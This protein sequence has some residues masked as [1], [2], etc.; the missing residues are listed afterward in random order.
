MGFESLPNRREVVRQAVKIGGVRVYLDTGF[1]PDGRV[2]E[3]FLAVEQTG[4]ERRWLY[5]EAA[6]SNSKLLQWG[7]PLEEVV[8]GW[9]GSKGAPFGP[10]QG[11][12]RIKYC[13]SILDYCGRYLG[14][15][16]QQREDLA[17]VPQS[18]QSD[19]P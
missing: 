11:D 3:I 13:S 2:G 10:V 7:A 16:Y 15:Y 18:T 9:V 8:E 4:S 5:D 1:Y 17:H 14:V 6:R 19:E 12:H